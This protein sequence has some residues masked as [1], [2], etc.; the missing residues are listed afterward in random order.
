MS[1]CSSSNKCFAK[2]GEPVLINAFLA[3]V[4][5]IS[6]ST[7][8]VVCDL[9]HCGYSSRGISDGPIHGPGMGG[10]LADFLDHD[11]LVGHS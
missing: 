6:I 10:G 3:S 7:R 8:T 9:H 1:D 5:S 2:I 4:Y 11:V